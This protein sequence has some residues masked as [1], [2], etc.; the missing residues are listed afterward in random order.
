M[1]GQVVVDARLAVKWL[2]NEV[3]TEKAIALAR[4]WTRSGVQPVSP[5]LMP[6]EVAN[7]LH[8]GH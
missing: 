2:L 3:H 5:Y 1:N 4:S 7:A 8:S 6:V